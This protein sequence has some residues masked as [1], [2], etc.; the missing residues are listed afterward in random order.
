MNSLSAPRAIEAKKLTA[1]LNIET[2]PFRKEDSG[3][4]KISQTSISAERRKF[5]RSDEYDSCPTYLGYLLRRTDAL[6]S[7]HDWL[8]A[9]GD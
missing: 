1:R 9:T 5:C 8:D 7:D 4:C 6:R 3:R 2:C